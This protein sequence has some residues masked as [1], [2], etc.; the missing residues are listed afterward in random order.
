M[1]HGCGPGLSTGILLLGDLSHHGHVIVFLF[2]LLLDFWACFAM[3][4]WE[5]WSYYY[6][7]KCHKVKS[8]LYTFQFNVMV[9]KGR[10]CS[11]RA[12]M[13]VG[14]LE[15]GVIGNGISSCRMMMEYMSVAS[16][17]LSFA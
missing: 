8:P 15:R 17:S 9:K 4:G 12:C 3:Y 5:M 1:W 11:G 2:L 16:L 14:E 13:G 7:V 10:C 6:D